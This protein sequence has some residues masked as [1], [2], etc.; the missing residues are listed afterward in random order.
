MGKG[1]A[2]FHCTKA[3]NG[4]IEE[5]RWSYDCSVHLDNSGMNSTEDNPDWKQVLNCPEGDLRYGFQIGGYQ[6]HMRIEKEGDCY[7]W[8]I[9]SD[10]EFPTDEPKFIF[11]L[12]DLDQ[13]QSFI[14]VWKEAERLGKLKEAE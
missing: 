9:Y 11:H 8:E 12:C 10:G 4:R 7:L 5:P 2:C 13:L 3:H 1:G 6:S 14:D